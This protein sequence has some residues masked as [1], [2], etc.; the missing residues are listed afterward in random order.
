[1]VSRTIAL[2]G[3]NLRAASSEHAHQ[4]VGLEVFDDLGGDEPAERV[5][6]EPGQVAE[7]SPPTTSRPLPWQRATISTLRSMPWAGM[8]RARAAV[9]GTRRARSR[10]RAH[11][12][13][14]RT[15]DVV[16]HALADL[17][18]GAAIGV[19]EPGVLVTAQRIR[20]RASAAGPGP[21]AGVRSPR[22][23]SRSW[24][25]VRD[26]AA[27]PLS[28]AGPRPPPCALRQGHAP[29]AGRGW[30]STRSASTSS[31]R[32]LSPPASPRATSSS[33]AAAVAT[34][35]VARRARPRTRGPWRRQT[36]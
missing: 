21:S 19:F 23:R 34:S 18:L 27:W 10:R 3:R 5:V 36:A 25:S 6:V 1:M 7:A 24:R 16:A 31:D 4:V 32:P 15:G 33:R 17:V 13:H 14:R 20:W 29:A 35:S 28:P 9:R 12:W 26:A 22:P 30:S 2:P 11:R 8:A